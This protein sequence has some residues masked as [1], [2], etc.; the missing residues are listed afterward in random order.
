MATDI[1]YTSGAGAWDELARYAKEQEAQRAREAQEEYARR[2]NQ[3]QM[4]AN[5]DMFWAQLGKGYQELNAKQQQETG[6]GWLDEQV[7]AV[8]SPTFG[9]SPEQEAAYNRNEALNQ[10]Y[11]NDLSWLDPSFQMNPALLGQS[12]GSQAQ[13]D[14]AA[15]AAQYAYMQQ[16]QGLANTPLQFQGSGQQQGLFDQ[17]GGIAGGQGAPTFMGNSAQQSALDRLMGVQAPQFSGDADQRA[18]FNQAMAASSN[19]GPNALAFDTS[20]RQAEQYGN[21]QDIIR[22]GGATAIEMANRQRQRADQEAWLRGQR[23]ADLADYA[24][25]GMSGSGMELLALGTDRQAAA[26]RNSLADLETAKALEE[27][28]LGAINSAAGLASTMRGQTA[29]EQGLLSSRYMSGLSQAADLANAMRSANYNEQAFL[30]TSARDQAMQGANIASQMRGQDFTERQY[31]DQRALDALQR[32]T[33][34]S[35]QMRDQTMQEQTSGR[36]AQQL[37]LNAFGD[38]AT[39]TR[40]QSFTEAQSRANAADEFARLNQSAINA[41]NNANTSFLQN[42]YQSMMNNRQTWDM[43]ALNQGIN[44]A[45]GLQNFD[46]RENQ[47]GFGQAGQLGMG[48]ANAYNNAAANYNNALMGTANQASAN[49]LNNAYSRNQIYPDLAQV[50]GEWTGLMAQ[51]AAGGAGGPYTQ[52][53]AGAGGAGGGM[54]SAP[55]SNAGTTWA[56]SAGGSGGGG[57][58]WQ[59]LLKMWGGK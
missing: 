12:A 27:R 3:A 10:R 53:A 7:A 42:A 38:M 36:N 56:S 5:P 6:R 37:A 13:A 39:N 58:N 21:L 1:D 48:N 9:M 18:A 44:V 46:Q 35:G 59:D 19:T 50:Y 24:E 22:G 4:E 8:S 45:Q 29:E 49:T 2:W 55:L 51:M 47:E 26:G 25:R 16:M 34:L 28:R 11:G 15:M 23:E 57:T 40:N 31:L 20:G 54:A 33:A 17:W 43:N 14:P 32:Q 52:G 41:A 30:N